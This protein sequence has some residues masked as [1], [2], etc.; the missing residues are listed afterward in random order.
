TAWNR[1]SSSP[2]AEGRTVTDA[3]PNVAVMPGELFQEAE[4]TIPAYRQMSSHNVIRIL[5]VDSHHLLREG[6]A[7]VINEQPD[8]RLVSQASSGPEA[9]QFYR[10]HRPDVMLMEIRLPGMNGIEALIA[11]RA[12][13]PK[14]RAVI[15]TTFGGDMEVQRALQAGACGYFLKTATPDEL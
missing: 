15:L 12:E 14:A 2:V 5:S 3:G 9:I 6:V 13:F 8:M 4:S 10:Q 1:R 11:I 7:T